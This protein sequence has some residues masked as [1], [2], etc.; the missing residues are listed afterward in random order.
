MYGVKGKQWLTNLPLLIA[1]LKIDYGLS[2]LKP[3][4]NLTYN[5]V[6]SGFQ[7]VQPIVLKLGLD[8]NYKTESDN[9]FMFTAKPTLED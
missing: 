1:Q 7:G 8:S 5:Y 9:C 6:L 2:H 4:N 3:V